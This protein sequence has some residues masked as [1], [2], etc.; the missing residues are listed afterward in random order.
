MAASTPPR[1]IFIIMPFEEPWSNDA[2]AF[3]NQCCKAL[4]DQYNIDWLRA[5]QIDRPGVITEQIF[6][7]IE[8]ADAL[9]ADIT[10]NNPNVLF[11]LGYARALD[12][13]I[14]VLNQDPKRSPFDVRVWRQVEY[15]LPPTTQSRDRILRQMATALQQGPQPESH[16]A[17]AAVQPGLVDI[18]L[19]PSIIKGPRWDFSPLHSQAPSA[20]NQR[21]LAVRVGIAAGVSTVPAGFELAEATDDLLETLVPCLPVN[22]LDKENRR[23]LSARRSWVASRRAS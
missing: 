1:H 5:D 2:H 10:G 23:R 9:I 17:S 22:E 7:A 19:G 11:E 13:P 12:K 18:N 21:W 3:I 14:V 4:C 15:H 8:D 6:E 20:P 16:A